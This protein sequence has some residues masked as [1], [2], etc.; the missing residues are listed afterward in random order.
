MGVL[1]AL[2]SLAVRHTAEAEDALRSALPDLFIQA[3]LRGHDGM[4]VAARYDAD[5][6]RVVT[7]GFDQTARIWVAGDDGFIARHVRLESERLSTSPRVAETPDEND[8]LRLE[9]VRDGLLALVGVPAG[10][11]IWTLVAQ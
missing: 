3:T 4:V 8:I 6:T 7:A 1:L 9:T 5:A 10:A 2:E 11:E